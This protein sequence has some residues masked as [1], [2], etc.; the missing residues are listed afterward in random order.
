M[1]LIAADRARERPDE[2]ALRDDR[3]ALRCAE[4]D[5]VLNRVV[6]GLHALVYFLLVIGYYIAAEFYL[7]ATPGKKAMGLKVVS[8]SG[9][10]TIGAVILRNVLRIV[11]GLPIFYLVGFICAAVRPDN[12][13]IGDIVAKTSVVAA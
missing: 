9:P 12:K 4:V 5:D 11:D 3:V 13:R 6:N 10:L 2:I 8:D 7:G 1:A